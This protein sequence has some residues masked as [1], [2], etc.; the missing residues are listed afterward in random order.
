MNDDAK[1][2]QILTD[3]KTIALVGWSP[4]PDRP[5]HRVAAFLAQQGYR[6][7]A[8]LQSQNAEQR[9]DEKHPGVDAPALGG[10]ELV[11]T[12]SLRERAVAAIERGGETRTIER[13]VDDVSLAERFF[14]EGEDVKIG[15]EEKQWRK[16]FES[17]E[18]YDGF[19]LKQLAK[20]E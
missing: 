17:G 16:I 9:A 11:M 8:L 10:R 19:E 4:K 3:V 12:Q 18:E 13:P 2:R 6:E 14:P 15:V 5:S 20:L 1:I 7:E